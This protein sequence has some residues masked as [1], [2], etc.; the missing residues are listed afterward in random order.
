MLLEDTELL[1]DL[2]SAAAEHRPD[3]LII[4]PWNSVT[5]DDT[6]AGF[7]GALKGLRT[8]AAAAADANGGKRPAIL[9]LHH[10]RK[11]RAEDGRKKGRDLSDMMAGSYQLFSK[12]RAGLFLA[13]ASPDINEDRVVLTITKASNHR[14]GKDESMPG[15]SAWR[16][17]PDG[18]ERIPDEDFPWDDYEGGGESGSKQPSITLSILREAFRGADGKSRWLPRKAAVE[19]LMRLSGLTSDSIPYKCLETGPGSKFGSWLMV[20]DRTKQLTFVGPMDGDI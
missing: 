9:V 19:E 12:S 4:D 10:P 13:P 6:A 8:I 11:L 14:R 16:M 7:S 1:G 15:R 5:R 2:C 18:F 3:L 17:H 20:D